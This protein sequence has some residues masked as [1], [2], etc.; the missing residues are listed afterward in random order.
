MLTFLGYITN[1]CE[2]S[3]MININIVKICVE[4]KPQYNRNCTF[5]TT[6]Y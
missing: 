5:P 4:Y 1:T 3:S 6:L 2:F